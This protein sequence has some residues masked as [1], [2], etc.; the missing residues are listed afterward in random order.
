M[1]QCTLDLLSSDIL[2][3]LIV[4]SSIN[5]ETLKNIA[6]ELNNGKDEKADGGD[7]EDRKPNTPEDKINE[8]LKE[9][10]EKRQDGIQ[11]ESNNVNKKERSNKYI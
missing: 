3:T 6:K 7:K 9:S 5:E 1:I 8:E 2:G 11:S 4:T 10:Q